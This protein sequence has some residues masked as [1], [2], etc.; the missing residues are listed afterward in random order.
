MGT[1]IQARQIPKVRF[2]AAHFHNIHNSVEIIN[3]HCRSPFKNNGFI[4]SH[5][6][7]D[8]NSLFRKSNYEDS[9]LVGDGN[10]AIVSVGK[11]ATIVAGDMGNS[12]SVG[13]N[14]IFQNGDNAN[15]MVANGNNKIIAYFLICF[16]VI[17]SFFAYCF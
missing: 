15:I 8:V 6:A 1:T 10:N 2:H 4:I 5:F 17:P 14:Y 3:C 13:N 12:N 7:Y 16:I 9:I 11:N